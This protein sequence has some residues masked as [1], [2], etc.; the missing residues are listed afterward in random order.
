VRFTARLS[1]ALPWTLSV[2]DS[3]GNRIAGGGGT[4]TALDWT[5]DATAAAQGTYAWT[6]EAGPAVLPARGT[7]GAKPA[8]LAIANAA[9]VPA[10]ISPNADGFDDTGLVTFRLTAPATV[11]ATLVDAAGNTVA[12]VATGQRPAG[13]QRF[14]VAV[15]GVADGLYTVVLRARGA[16]SEVI[17]RVPVAVNRTLGY[18]EAFQRVF[19]PNGDGRLDT[20]GLGF[21]L[22]KPAQVRV[23]VLRQRKWVANAFKG[24]L[25]D[26]GQTITWDGKKPQGR[27]RDG[28][29][30]A[31]VIATNEVGSVSQRTPFSVDTTAPSLRLYSVQPLRVRVLE[32]VRL[33]IQLNGKWT[34]IDRK[35]PG[36]VPIPRPA[37]LRKLRVVARDA[38][39]NASAPLT[40]RR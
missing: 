35:R 16:T 13:E 24:P 26:G 37:V 21:L 4:G 36:L 23:R 28:E 15:D 8:A 12:T 30:E 19:S 20:L 7:V 1:A 11:T 34:T 29:Y 22:L 40:Y 33:T 31:E 9:A 32:P 27:L 5:W 18:V 6:M 38:A 25:S 17:A 14:S 2:T 3:A 39:G 10:V